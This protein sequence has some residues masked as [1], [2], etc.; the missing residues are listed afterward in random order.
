LK[1][2]SRKNRIIYESG[3]FIRAGQVT[4]PEKV[5]DVKEW[6]DKHSFYVKHTQ[7]NLVIARSVTTRQSSLLLLIS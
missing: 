3:K 4:I 1:L 7:Q 5:R 6:G 2:I